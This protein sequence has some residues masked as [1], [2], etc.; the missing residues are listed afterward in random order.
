MAA[1][2]PSAALSCGFSLIE[3]MV[4]LAI[5]GILAA[6]AIPSYQQPLMRSRR[7]DAQAELSAI[8][9]AQERYRSNHPSYAKTLAQLG[10]A[11]LASSRYD[12]ALA[13]TTDPPFLAGY[14]ARAVPKPSDD[15]PQKRDTACQLLFITLQSGQL[16]NGDSNPGSSAARALCWS[17]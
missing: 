3:L 16:V 12:F 15:N 9:Q 13:A 11:P 1:V 6:I 4:A 17:R 5:V 14:Q 7:A 8:T 10:Y 2:P